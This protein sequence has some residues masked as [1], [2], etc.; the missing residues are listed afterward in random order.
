M[1]LEKLFP[2]KTKVT[3]AGKEYEL[4]NH[5][6]EDAIWGKQEGVT[7]YDNDEWDLDAICR[8]VYRLIIDKSDFAK[9]E[10]KTYDEDGDEIT[11]YLG[12]AA[13]LASMVTTEQEKIGLIKSVVECLNQSAP[14]EEEGASKGKS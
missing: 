2:T 8:L 3:I 13:R 14:D 11:N 7:I 6:L 12:G 4:R 1:E 9:I 5:T 10:F